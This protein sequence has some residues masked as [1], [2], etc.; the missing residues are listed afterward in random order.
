MPP[1]KALQVAR[2]ASLDLVEISPGVNPPICKILDWG[3]FKYEQQKQ[4]QSQK[5]K[6]KNVEVKVIRLS[7]KIGEHDLATKE[8]QARKFLGENDKVK[9]SLFFK[10][11]EITHKD[12]GEKV[13]RNFITRLEDIAKVDTEISFSGR[14]ISITLSPNK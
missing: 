6:Q 5:K 10:G 9:L 12:L 3:K 4:E 11:R 14:E 1:S 13:L 7:A 2:D 8:K